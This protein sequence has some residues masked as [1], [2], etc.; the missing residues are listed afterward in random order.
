[1]ETLGQSLLAVEESAGL[2]FLRIEFDF[3]F[4][5]RFCL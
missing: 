4:T 5:S 3:V 1:M 2:G